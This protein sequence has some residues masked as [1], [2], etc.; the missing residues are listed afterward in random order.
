MNYEAN[1]TNLKSKL[2]KNENDMKDNDI[3]AGEVYRNMSSVGKHE[4]R[5]AFT[6]SVPKLKRGTIS[7]LMKQT[8]IY[9]SNLIENK[10]EDMSNIKNF[11]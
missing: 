11:F 4:Q 9:F 8:G 3:Q 6:L 7:R 1:V 2:E 10:T 5:S